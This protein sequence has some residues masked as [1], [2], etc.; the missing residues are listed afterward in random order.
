MK[1]LLARIICHFKGHIWGKWEKGWQINPK[2][3]TDS[4]E[5][6]NQKEPMTLPYKHKQCIRRCGWV[7]EK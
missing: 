6:F 5:G 1:R 7:L 3:Q 4:D 2:W